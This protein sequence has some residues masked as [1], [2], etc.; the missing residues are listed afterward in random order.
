M[1]NASVLHLLPETAA[2]LVE[3]IGMVRAGRLIDRL[4]GT[5]LPVPKLK[6]RRGAPAF[7]ALVQIIGREAALRLVEVFGG[8][9]VWVPRCEDAMREVRDRA[10]RADFDELTKSMS[11]RDAVIEL[12]RRYDVVDRHIWRILKQVDDLGETNQLALL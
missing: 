8:E 10:I 11:A 1:L 6:N 3:T 2:Q 7:D 5:T 12:V 4:G 9:N